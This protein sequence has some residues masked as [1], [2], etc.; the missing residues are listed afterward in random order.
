VAADVEAFP[1][2]LLLSAGVITIPIGSDFVLHSVAV[3]G[4]CVVKGGGLLPLKQPSVL[5]S[6]EQDVDH[7]GRAEADIAV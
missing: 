7:Q 6:D 3:F 5:I 2:V 4:F 1:I